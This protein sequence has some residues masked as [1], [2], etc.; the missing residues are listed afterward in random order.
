MVFQ[1][2]AFLPSRASFYTTFLKYCGRGESLG[3]TTCLKAVVRVSRD[4]LSVRYFCSMKPLF[5]P[6]EFNGCHKTAYNDELTSDH[7]LFWGY[8]R[9]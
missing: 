3:T 4:M 8:Y 1:D 7:H 2:V 6:V 5:V 9:I